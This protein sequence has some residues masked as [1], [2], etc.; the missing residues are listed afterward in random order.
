METRP[1]G[2]H[3]LL[4][5]RLTHVDSTYGQLTLTQLDLNQ[6]QADQ[7][8]LIQLDRISPNQMYLVMT[9]VLYENEKNKCDTI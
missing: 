9:M 8:R 1:K 7:P 6:L 2:W 4:D 3:T 5:L